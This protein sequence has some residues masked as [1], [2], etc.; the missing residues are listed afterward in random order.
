MKE[1]LL[2]GLHENLFFFFKKYC[3]HDLIVNAPQEFSALLLSSNTK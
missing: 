1:I 3:E 2:S